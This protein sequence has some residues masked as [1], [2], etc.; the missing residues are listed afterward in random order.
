[1]NVIA[2]STLYDQLGGAAAVNAAV[3]IFYG[4]VMDDVRINHFFKRVN[5]QRQIAKQKAFLTTAFGGPSHYTGKD[6]RRGHARVVAMGLNDGH[7]DIVVDLLR[8]TLSE[9]KVPTPLI[10]Q[11]ETIAQN[12][13]NDVLNK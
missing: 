7:F 1:M 5:M 10:D 9:L 2:T 4:K 11:V 13:R 6:M 12:V 8:Q 3:E